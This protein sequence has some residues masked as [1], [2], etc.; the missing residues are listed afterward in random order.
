MERVS[1]RVTWLFSGRMLATNSSF[2]PPT[3]EPSSMERPYYKVCTWYKWQL[4][5]E[6]IKPWTTTSALRSKLG[7][8]AIS[9][10]LWKNSLWL[11]ELSHKVQSNGTWDEEEEMPPRQDTLLGLVLG[12]RPLL[13]AKWIFFSLIRDTQYAGTKRLLFTVRLSIWYFPCI[14]EATLWWIRS[15]HMAWLWWKGA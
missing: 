1:W 8:L 2:T 4:F 12:V 10:S 11:C 6:Y 3:Q 7:L 9:C 5:M 13:L 15:W 14:C